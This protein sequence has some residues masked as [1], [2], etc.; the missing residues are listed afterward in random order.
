MALIMVLALGACGNADQVTET[1]TEAE[2]TEGASDEA[3]AS[4]EATSDEPITLTM[5]DVMASDEDS[6]VIRPI[7]EEW[8]AAN[9][10][11]QIVREGFDVENYKMKLKTAMAA[12]EAPDLIYGWGAGFM[13]PFVE[14]GKLLPLDDYL[15][16]ETLDT[17]YQGASTYAQFDGST[18][19]L[20]YSMW[21]AV[22]Y[23]NTELF[24]QY[25]VKVP[26]T[27][28]ELLE[29]VEVFRANGVGPIGVG[30]KDRWTSMFYHNVLA[31]RTAGADAVNATLAGNGSY[32]TPEMLDAATKLDE[33]VKA[34][35]F[36]D[37]AMGLG[38]DDFVAMFKQGDVP[39]MLQGTW[40]AGELEMDEYP[41]KGKAVAR[42]FPVLSGG[43]SDSEYLGG[44]IDVYMANSNTPHKEEVVRALE[45]IA[46]EMSRRGYEAGTG[47]PVYEADFDE[48]SVDRVTKE[49]LEMVKDAEG[50]TLAWDTFLVGEDAQLHL[51]LVQEI[52]AGIRTPEDFVKEMQ[53][54]NEKSE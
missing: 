20:P 10:N 3:G 21:Y 7:V 4:T 54:I 49:A 16:D 13:E 30:A 18:Y 34:E 23:C 29:A 38:Y 31:L 53:T 25:D 6:R 11:V 51:N 22:F 37:G 47:L 46:T 44:S 15:S 2:A 24:E 1:S 5:W 45:F 43:A 28:E 8:N 9:P 32:D 42:K 14:A 33:L 26:D 27:Y 40:L 12:N 19:A 36:I 52:F 17:M 50:F 41:I 39:M 35:A 48:S